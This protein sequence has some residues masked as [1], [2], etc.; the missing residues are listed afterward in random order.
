MV[1]HYSVGNMPEAAAVPDPN[2]RA[3]VGHGHLRKFNRE[4]PKKGAKAI[5]RKRS[6]ISKVSRKRNRGVTS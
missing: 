2:L 1:E 5:K 4:R 6:K 3:G